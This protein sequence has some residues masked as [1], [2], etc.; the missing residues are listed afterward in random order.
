MLRK[1]DLSACPEDNFL[2]IIER[3]EDVINLD[4][5]RNIT[6]VDCSNDNKC[7]WYSILDNSSHL[8]DVEDVDCLV[9]GEHILVFT[10]YSK[11][12]FEC[13]LLSVEDNNL[14][15]EIL[16]GLNINKVV[17]FSI[18][19]PNL[20]V[21][22]LYNKPCRETLEE[23]GIT[24]ES[25]NRERLEK[26]FKGSI[27]NN[28]DLRYFQANIAEEIYN[29]NFDTIKYGDIVY[30]VQNIKGVL[31]ICSGMVISSDGACNLV[32]MANDKY[33]GKNKTSLNLHNGRM[34]KINKEAIIS[35]DF[36]LLIE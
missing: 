35:E 18:N 17:S 3:L 31:S 19:D 25:I 1:V 27:I 6:E 13:K 8:M 34:F 30:G 2:P 23:L 11:L 16:G 12:I 15:V 33:K 7:K 29:A 24:Y 4:N 5:Y 14:V 20:K 32:I 9:V 10:D 36:K 21:V 26:I 22:M 28:S